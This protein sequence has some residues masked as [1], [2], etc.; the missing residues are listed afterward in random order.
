[1]ANGDSVGV[2]TMMNDGTI[3]LELQTLPDDQDQ[4]ELLVQYPPSHPEYGI[5]LAHLGGIQ[6][7]ESVL[8]PPFPDESV[9]YV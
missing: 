7:G 2:A 9:G 1:M 6:P 3:T 4:G 8:I 5:I